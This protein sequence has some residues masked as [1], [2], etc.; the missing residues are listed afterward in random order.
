M[1]QASDAL[2]IDSTMA[3]L[4]NSRSLN[5]VSKAILPISDL[6]VVCA[7]CVIAYDEEDFWW[8]IWK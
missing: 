2:L 1:P 8:R 4:S 3:K 7:N 6:I 5:T